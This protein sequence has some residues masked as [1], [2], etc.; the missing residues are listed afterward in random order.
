MPCHFHSTCAPVVAP[1]FHFFFFFKNKKN[2]RLA[3]YFL[4]KKVNKIKYLLYYIRERVKLLYIFFKLCLLVSESHWL[5]Y[6]HSSGF[7]REALGACLIH[8]IVM[9]QSSSLKRSPL[10]FEGGKMPPKQLKTPT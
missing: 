2:G 9:V 3:F 6:G 4:I 8:G 1:I 10:M 7:V 5:A